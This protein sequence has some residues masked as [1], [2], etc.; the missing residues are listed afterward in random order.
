[1]DA[2]LDVGEATRDAWNATRDTRNATRDGRNS[3]R[4]VKPL[5]MYATRD[6]DVDFQGRNSRERYTDIDH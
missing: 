1:M 4:D 6:V 2:M 3:T 5:F